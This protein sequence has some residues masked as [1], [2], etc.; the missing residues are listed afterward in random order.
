MT[1]PHTAMLTLRMG[2]IDPHMVMTTLHTIMINQYMAVINLHT[3]AINLH[4]E[5]KHLMKV[6]NLLLMTNDLHMVMINQYMIVEVINQVMEVTAHHTTNHYT[7]TRHLMGLTNPLMVMKIHHTEVLNRLMGLIS[8]TNQHMALERMAHKTRIV[9]VSIT[10][11]A[12]LITVAVIKTTI[13]QAVMEDPMMEV[14]VIILGHL[15]E[16]A[17]HHQIYLRTVATDHHQTYLPMAATD[18]HQINLHM[19]VVDHH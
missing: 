6:I 17:V 18:R 11:E 13:V 2:M 9:E 7:M 16:A 15:M 10:K 12:S 19:V 3:T 5:A 4:M 8:M 1:N 14:K